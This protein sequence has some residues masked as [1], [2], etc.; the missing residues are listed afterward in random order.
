M[1]NS[2]A[3][4]RIS[5]KPLPKAKLAA[6]RKVIITISW[7]AASLNHYDLLSLNETNISEKYTQ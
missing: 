7:S 5:S 2:V 4:L 6:K 3:G 1:T